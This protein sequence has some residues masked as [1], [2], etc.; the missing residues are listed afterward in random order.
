MAARSKLRFLGRQ[1]GD[2]GDGTDDET[3]ADGTNERNGFNDSET[4][5]TEDTQDFPKPVYISDD[6]TQKRARLAQKCCHLKRDK[7]ISDTWIFEGRVLA[8]DLHQHVHEIKMRTFF[9]HEII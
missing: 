6:L 3:T 9:L 5:K 7:K 2:E 1:R 4:D 8:K